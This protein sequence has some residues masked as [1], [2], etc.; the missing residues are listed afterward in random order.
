MMPEETVR[1]RDKHRACRGEAD[2]PG[3]VSEEGYCPCERR[4]Y[5]VRWINAGSY[6]QAS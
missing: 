2:L 4:H 5:I 1:D 3:Y 6:G